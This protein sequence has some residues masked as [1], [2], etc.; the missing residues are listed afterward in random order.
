ML[1]KIEALGYRYLSDPEKRALTR[2]LAAM[3]V[4]PLTEEVASVAITLRQQKNIRTPDAIIAA[5]AMAHNLELWTHNIK[6][7][8]HISG[9]KLFDPLA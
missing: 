7:F 9:L 8:R 1:A 2:L 3:V 6:D 4:L 5:T